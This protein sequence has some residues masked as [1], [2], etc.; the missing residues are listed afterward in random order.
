MFYLIGRSLWMVQ[1]LSLLTIKFHCRHWNLA[2]QTSCSPM[3]QQAAA[4]HY[5]LINTIL[6]FQ[7]VF[8]VPGPNFSS[9]DKN[10]TMYKRKNVSTK[11]FLAIMWL[12]RSHLRTPD[13]SFLVWL[14]FMKINSKVISKL[15]KAL[16]FGRAG[17]PSRLN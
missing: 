15:T 7:L 5:C 16:T 1:F 12:S 10:L 11:L 14:T 8:F 4:L 6:V 13:K 2:K 17:Q 3:Q 9:I